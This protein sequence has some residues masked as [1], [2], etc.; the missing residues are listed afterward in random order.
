MYAGL[1]VDAC[2]GQ[3]HA[4]N[5]CDDSTSCVTGAVMLMLEL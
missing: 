3:Q 5:R 1:K 2:G 4:G